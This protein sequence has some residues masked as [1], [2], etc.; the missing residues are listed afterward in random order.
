MNHTVQGSNVTADQ[1]ASMVKESVKMQETIV[2]LEDLLRNEKE[3]LKN[4][5]LINRIRG[6]DKMTKFYTGLKSWM[7]FEILYNLV[8]PGIEFCSAPS[9]RSLPTEE[10]F[11]LVLMK[12]RLNLPDKDLAFR[13][14]MS[15]NTVSTYLSKW[16]DVMYCRLARNF[17]IW[18]TKA[19]LDKSTPTTFPGIVSIINYFEIPLDGFFNLLGRATTHSRNNLKYFI[20]ITPTG[21]ISYISQGYSEERATDVQITLDSKKNMVVLNDETFLN[22]LKEGDVVLADRG[23]LVELE[24]KKRGA[25]LRTPSFA[26]RRSRL[27][28]QETLYSRKVSKLRIHA[29]KVIGE[30]RRTFKILTDCVPYTGVR[31]EEEKLLFFDK[32][33]FVC[34]C[35]NNA[36]PVASSI[37]AAFG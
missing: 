14:H 23:F 6:N 29:E 20:S 21:S 26:D 8:L 24:V 12:L 25:I 33:V 4:E 16:I 3:L 15:Q 11:L 2:S 30:L 35:L 22:K 27:T 7:L 19:T 13:F 1:M 18:P 28:Q 34:C 37:H 31:S 32:V 17:M 5:K 36:N 10:Q 9:K